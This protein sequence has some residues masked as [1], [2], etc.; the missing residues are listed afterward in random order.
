M[1]EVN[2]VMLNPEGDMVVRAAKAS[3]G[4]IFEP[5]SFHTWRAACLR[6]AAVVVD[7]GA[8]TGL[9]ALYAR[10]AGARVYAFEPNP[11]NYERLL[12][13]V[14]ANPGGNGIM[15]AFCCAVGQ[16][17]ARVEMTDL[18]NRPRL[19]SAGKVREA[20]GGRI[21]MV[22][23]D[24]LNLPRCDAIKLDVEG[25]ELEVLRGA[26]RTIAGYLPRLILEANDEE[27]R[28]ALDREL[29]QYGYGPGLRV[30]ARNLIYVHPD[31]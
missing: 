3:Q 6:P 23:L 11:A 26:A 27:H 15:S 10:Q 19:T 28:D 7:V 29:S 20:A 30:D 18:E 14:E 25:M 22:S 17:P 1:I 8:Y 13:N 12:Q 24:S 2:G 4:G 5:V 31:R 21:E 9:Y 16:G